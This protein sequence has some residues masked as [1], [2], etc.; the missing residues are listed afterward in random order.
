MPDSIQDADSVIS[1]KSPFIEPELPYRHYTDDA[2]LTGILSVGLIRPSCPNSTHGAGV[3]LT[4][5]LIPTYAGAGLRFIAE[6]IGKAGATLSAFIDLGL[7]F[8]PEPRPGTGEY[9]EHFVSVET[10]PEGLPVRS[11]PMLSGTFSR[12]HID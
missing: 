1:L 8:K 4:R 3:Y 12:E 9:L 11:Y 6:V 2:G 7:D 5:W 10:H